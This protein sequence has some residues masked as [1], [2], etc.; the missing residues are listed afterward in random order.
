M[1]LV[2]KHT[3]AKLVQVLTFMNTLKTMPCTLQMKSLDATLTS[4]V[5]AARGIDDEVERECAL[6]ILSS[7]RAV[8]HGLGPGGDL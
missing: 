1:H 6:Q 3:L 5:K 7:A 4:A 8:L 2:C